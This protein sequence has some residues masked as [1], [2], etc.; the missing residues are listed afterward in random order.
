MR[1][2]K[3]YACLCTLVSLETREAELGQL[4]GNDIAGVQS[5]FVFKESKS[6]HQLDLDDLSGAIRV[7]VVLNIC[8]LDCRC[9][10]SAEK[11]LGPPGARHIR[12]PCE[13]EASR[14]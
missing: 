10:R 6:V 2:D 1:V 9:S 7:E 4:T 11:V 3:S 14:P 13:R 8:L 5:V 12:K